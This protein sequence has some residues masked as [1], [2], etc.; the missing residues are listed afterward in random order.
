MAR[1][2]PQ[3][4]LAR[5][6]VD[7]RLA[8]LDVDGLVGPSRHKIDLARSECSHLS[9]MATSNELVV[10]DVFQLEV[11]AV[12]REARHEVPKALVNGIELPQGREQLLALKSRLRRLRD[13]IGFLERVDVVVDSL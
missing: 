10:D 4:A 1:S 11:D 9:G 6:G 12:R 13:D 8:N 2:G 5:G 3:L 7:H